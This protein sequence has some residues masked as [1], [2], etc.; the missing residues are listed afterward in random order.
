MTKQEIDAVIDYVA[1]KMGLR[2]VA[3]LTKG[4]LIYYLEHASEIDPKKI[5]PG[6]KQAKIA[7][8]DKE[9]AKLQALKAFLE[10]ADSAQVAQAAEAMEAK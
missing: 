2:L 7:E 10:K 6:Q 4:M 1:D 5:I 9:I 8:V 3:N